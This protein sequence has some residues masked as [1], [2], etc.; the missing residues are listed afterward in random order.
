MRY[1][2]RNMA[3]PELDNEPEYASAEEAEYADAAASQA[4]RDDWSIVTSE[5]KQIFYYNG[6]PFDT[7]SEALSAAL[8]DIMSGN[9]V[10]DEGCKPS[11]LTGA[12]R[13]DRVREI[14]RQLLEAA[15]QEKL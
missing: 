6:T 4:R 8:L 10:F 5:H 3:K 15:K 2:G 13:N 9:G 12:L 7:K 1:S 14:L 11:Y